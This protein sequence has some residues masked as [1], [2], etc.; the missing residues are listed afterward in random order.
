[1]NGAEGAEGDGNRGFG[2]TALRILSTAC[3]DLISAYFAMAFAMRCEL[4]MCL[5]KLRLK[6]D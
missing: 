1:L 4:L 6:V 2:A 5:S 3:V